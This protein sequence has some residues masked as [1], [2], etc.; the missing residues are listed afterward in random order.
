[1]A[2]GLAVC[3]RPFGGQTLDKFMIFWRTKVGSNATVNAR[4]AV[5]DFSSAG[6]RI[7]GDCGA[8]SQYADGAEGCAINA[9]EERLLEN[10]AVRLGW[11]H[12]CMDGF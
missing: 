12:P 10:A 6:K 4:S 9:N 1:M 2:L 5:G 3:V 7:A 8:V 11:R